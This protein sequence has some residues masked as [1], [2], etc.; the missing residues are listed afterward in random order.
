M[1]R[2]TSLFI[3][4]H[5]LR[6]LCGRGPTLLGLLFVT[7]IPVVLLAILIDQLY[8]GGFATL[9]WKALLTFLQGFH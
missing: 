6:R 3:T 2:L 9:V 4:F 8:P 5:V 1:R 7:A